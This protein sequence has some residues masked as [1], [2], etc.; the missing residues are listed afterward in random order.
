MNFSPTTQL[1]EVAP[2]CLS[3]FENIGR[4]FD[5]TR[6]A[7]VAKVLPG[8]FYVSNNPSEVI[9][10]VL[11]SCV[12]ACIRDPIAGVGGMN[13]F[14][15]AES[16][17][18]PSKAWANAATRFGLHAM[19]QLINTIIKLG[20]E[21]S[22]FEIKIFGGGRIINAMRDI[23]GN[24]VAFVRSFLQAEHLR[25]KAEDV[26]GRQGRKLYYY[27]YTGRALVKTLP[28]IPQKTLAAQER[29]YAKKLAEPKSGEI[30][31]F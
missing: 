10:T 29:Q 30:E 11:G 28:H 4:Y 23:G 7:W 12:S 17:G 13:H 2:P 31:L 24:N 8:D 27:P 14:M 16:Q 6:S 9:A 19:E 15:L 26:L 5:K 3:G 1:S 20:G 18:D 22:R 25:I 21:K